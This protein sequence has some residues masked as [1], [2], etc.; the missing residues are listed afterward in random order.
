MGDG[1]VNV[2]QGISIS[3]QTYY[4]AEE[5]TSALDGLMSFCIQLWPYSS[6]DELSAGAEV[7]F[8]F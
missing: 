4:S 3:T 1:V 7:G 5:S 2:A 6:I 8:I